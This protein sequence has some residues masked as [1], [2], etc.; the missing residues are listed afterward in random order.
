MNIPFALE[1]IHLKRRGVDIVNRKYRWAT[2]YAQPTSHCEH[3][4]GSGR[5]LDIWGRCALERLPE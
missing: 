4:G 5:S 2:T 3:G 1:G